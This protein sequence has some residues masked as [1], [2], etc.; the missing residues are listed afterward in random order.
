[1]LKKYYN[2]SVNTNAAKSGKFLSRSCFLMRIKKILS[3]FLAAVM[4]FGALSVGFVGAAAEVDY[5]AQYRWL[6]EALQNEY[7]REL[8]NYTLTNATLSNET[9]G[10][11]VEAKGFAYDHKVVA[12]DNENGD[13]LKA[14]NRFYYI[15]ENLMSYKYGVGC[16]DPSTLLS[17]ISEKIIAGQLYCETEKTYEQ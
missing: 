5:E 8:T 10:F 14:S 15:A 2:D 1:M 13:I 9:G 17:Y 4:L 16:Y 6:A 12:R 7:V 3:V 11:D